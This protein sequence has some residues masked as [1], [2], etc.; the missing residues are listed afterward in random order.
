M[1]PPF[2]SR[3]FTESHRKFIGKTQKKGKFTPCLPKRPECHHP[4]NSI[5]GN[6]EQKLP[7]LSTPKK[8]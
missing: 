4:V 8:T 2:E 5:E 6:T 1:K 3:N 7:S